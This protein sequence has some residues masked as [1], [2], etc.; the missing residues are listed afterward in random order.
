MK[1]KGFTHIVN[2]RV[3]MK[4]VVFVVM[5]WIALITPLV[6]YAAPAYE[7]TIQSDW[8]DLDHSTGRSE[9]FGGKWI[10]AS[11]FVFKKRSKNPIS[12][13]NLDITR[14]GKRLD[15]ISG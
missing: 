12:L 1:E 9:Q 11:T 6:I 13:H 2:E 7:I 3:R 10:W 14:N 4:S 5:S 15:H 8:K